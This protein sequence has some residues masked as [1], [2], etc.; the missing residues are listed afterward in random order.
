MKKV[1]S[2]IYP[3]RLET[4][5]YKHKA[6]LKIPLKEMGQEH[7]WNSSYVLLPSVARFLRWRI[8]EKLAADGVGTC[9]LAGF[10]PVLTNN[11][12]FFS[13]EFSVMVE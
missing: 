9:F 4:K 5:W 1:L 3:C 6:P 13:Q 2:S 12:Q 7:L 10:M 11:V 8:G